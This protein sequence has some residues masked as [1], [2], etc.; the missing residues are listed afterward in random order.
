MR[1]NRLWQRCLAEGIGAGFLVFAGCGAIVVDA[2]SGGGVTPV[3]IGATFGL[4]V[5]A[6]VYALGH[7][8][9][10]H[11]NPAVTVAF[12]ACRRFPRG[13]VLPYVAAQ[14]VGAIVGASLLR[15]LFGAVGGLG[16]TRPASSAWQA[17][18][19]EAAMTAALMFVVAAVATDGRAVGS[20]AG[21]AIGAV[22]GLEA[23]F[24]GPISGASM[25]PA[26]SLGPAVAALDG[27]FLWIYVLAPLVGAVAGAFAYEAV[28]VEEPRR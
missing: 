28:R 17:L 19:L 21:V 14:A 13:E 18:G 24:G 23:I 3:G 25:N 8:S 26:R 6:L 27:R 12:A 22:V 15:V 20:M 10:A 11:L 1:E 7:V 4:V 5:L 2:V 9:G 16:A